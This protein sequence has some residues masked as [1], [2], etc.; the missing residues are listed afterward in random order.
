MCSEKDILE[1]PHFTEHGII[2]QS[3]LGYHAIL[4]FLY[5]A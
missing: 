4:G 1:M 2:R 3:G 5:L